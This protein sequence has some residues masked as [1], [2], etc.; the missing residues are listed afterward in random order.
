MSKYPQV[1]IG[2]FG[3]TGFYNLLDDPEPVKI[4]TPYGAPSGDALVGSIGDKTVAFLPRHGTSHQIPPH[5]VNY[6]ANLWAMKELGAERILAPCA[7]GSLQ[8]DVVP[9]EFVILDQFVDRTWGRGDTFYDGP[10]VTHVSSADPYCDDLRIVAIESC[11]RTGIPFHENGTVVVIQG[12]RFSTRAE[13]KWFASQGW[14]VINM[15]QYPEAFLARELD[16]CYCGIALI[17][18][19]DA[20]V[21]SDSAV[22]NHDVQQVFAENL[23]KVKG[24]L[25]DMIPRIPLARENCGCG[26]AT[27]YSE[28]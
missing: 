26:E 20:G 22:T 19:Y 11:K 6:R 28:M 7:C 14:G 24:L 25:V 4:H 23:D 1:D 8:A 16:L 10:A 21:D 13:S 17:T 9:G 15:T 5:R 2:V 12:P 3:G 27:L 18:D